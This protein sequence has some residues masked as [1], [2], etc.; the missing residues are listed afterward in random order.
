MTDPDGLPIKLDLDRINRDAKFDGFKALSTTTDLTIDEI[1]SKYRDLFE[2]EHTFRALK[3][4]LEIRPVF[5]WTDKRIKGHVCMCFIAFTLFNH[6]RNITQLQ[7]RQIV[8]ALDKMQMSHIK[9][10][11]S[12]SNLY[13][14]SAI[15]DD[16]L[17][18]IQKLKLK[19]PNDTTP[20]KAINQLFI[21]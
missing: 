11:K 7:Y 12:K 16:Q 3:S 19:T 2:V 20:E 13:L 9:D 17:T 8:S 1:L 6:L 21:E 4:Q 10:N 14:R 5:H 15:S 18:I